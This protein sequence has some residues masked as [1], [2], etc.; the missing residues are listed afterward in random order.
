M[1]LQTLE[2]IK[3]GHFTDETLSFPGSA[4]DFHLIVGPNEAGKSTLRRAVTELLFGMPLRSPM[5]FRHA[6]GDLRLGAVIESEAG[7]LAFHRSRSR[8]SLRTP[9]DEELEPDALTRHLGAT[10]EAVFRRMFCLDLE[11]LLEGGR[12]ILDA[13]DDVGRM[14]FQSAAGISGLGAVRDALAREAEALYT[15]RKAGNRVF[16]QALQRHDD[17]RRRLRESSVNAHRWSD[18]ERRAAD[19][20]EALAQARK[21][22]EALEIQRHRLER[23]RRVT[24]PVAHYRDTLARIEAMAGTVRFPREALRELA[25]SEQAIAQHAQALDIHGATV[26][27]LQTRLDALSVDER[28]LASDEAVETL[29]RLTHACAS[30]PRRLERERNRL[31]ALQTAAATLAGELGWPRSEEALRETAPSRI[32]LG[33]LATLLDEFTRIDHEHRAARLAVER[34]R[35]DIDTL[36]KSR[37][38]PPPALAPGL[39]RALEAARVFVGDTARQQSLHRALEA[40]LTDLDTAATGLGRWRMDAESLQ[41]LML[42]GEDELNALR[43]TRAAL[44]HRHDAAV[45]RL[46][47]TR[48]ALDVA[49]VELEQF[50]AVDSLVTLEDVRRARR[51]RDELWTRIKKGEEPLSTGAPGLDA[52]IHEADRLVDSQRDRA[53][54]AAQLTGL[55]NA[56]ERLVTSASHGEARVRETRAALDDFDARWEVR[57]RDMRLPDMA[58]TGLSSWMAQRKAVLAAAE[59]VRQRQ[60][61]SDAARAACADALGVLSGALAACGHPV[62]GEPGLEE[63]CDRAD[64]LLEAHRDAEAAARSASEQLARDRAHLQQRELELRQ[65]E[66]AREQWETRWQEALR[67]A[68]LEARWMSPDTARGALES[69]LRILDHLDDMASIR[70]EQIEPLQQDLDE[71]AVAADDLAASLGATDRPADI[72]AFARAMLTRLT[73]AREARAQRSRLQ[74]EQQEAQEQ[75]RRIEA[76]SAAAEAGLAALY[77]LAGSND[78][79]SL[80]AQIAAS[81]EL[82]ELESTLHTHRENILDLGD[83]LTFDV[84]LGEFD[85]VDADG[86]TQRLEDT[87]RQVGDNVREQNDLT[88][89]LTQ[90]RATLA[91]IQGG[92]DAADAEAERREA[93]A[94][95]AD[96][97]ERYVKVEAAHRL[98]RW[99]IDRYRE[100]KQG[101][102]LARAGQLFARLTLGGFGRLVTDLESTPPRLIAV[103][104]DGARVTIEGLSE[105]TRDQLYLALRLAA[106]ELQIEADRPLPFIA[107]DLFVNYH[108]E[109]AQAGLQVMFELARRTQVVFLTHHE[110]LAELALALQ[111]ETHCTRLAPVAS[112]A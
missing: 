43:N 99:A 14:L 103:R 83:G 8:K 81:D 109:R 29:S 40:A 20:E 21:R 45:E 36:E 96:T 39:G 75:C 30:H 76:A 101:P 58:L 59:A 6:V 107:D 10:T 78:K 1:R 18:L 73:T 62:A 5:G 85:S 108:D 42:P 64:A 70:R 91:G 3:Y 46:R 13:S 48:E 80:R 37:P 88:T 74:A 34:L 50:A 25:E 92:S 4:C 24:K 95:L 94:E 12:S 2:L 19:L 68:S 41:A 84:L 72:P 112:R 9:D 33:A 17:A 67:F 86:L 53:E 111:P 69:A 7:T 47:E 89:E 22:Y 79:S 90:V 93:L 32:A 27:T 61:E 54:E 82:R 100:R 26:A 23:I 104:D 11:A 110:H 15:P 56:L 106:L 71:L 44:E 57:A 60:Q 98:L 35:A 55:R 16:Y 97:A 65:A 51:S 87:V 28:I 31:S 77:A 66:Q 102:L 63:L 38:L 105:G 52:A 49:R